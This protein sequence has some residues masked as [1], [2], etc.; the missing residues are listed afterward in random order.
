[1]SD[2]TLIC[3]PEQEEAL[4]GYVLLDGENY[5]DCRDL[6]PGVHFTLGR[7]RAVWRA[8]QVLETA[9][10]SIDIPGVVDV[11]RA[12]DRLTAAGGKGAIVALT[13]PNVASNPTYAGIA[14]ARQALEDSARLRMIAKAADELRASCERR[15]SPS[16]SLAAF[17]SRVYGETTSTRDN[18]PVCLKDSLSDTFAYIQGLQDNPDEGRLKTGFRDLDAKLRL[19]PG[20]FFLLGGRPAMGKSALGDQIACQMAASGH[21]VMEA[22]FEMDVRRQTNLRR[23]ACHSR[24]GISQIREGKMSDGEHARVLTAA[25]TMRPWLGRVYDAGTELITPGALFGA[26]RRLKEEVGL[27]V[28]VV[29]Y[30]Q[31]MRPNGGGGGSNPNAQIAEVSRALKLMARDLDVLVIGMV[32]LSRKVE[33]REN[34]RPMTSDLR[35]SGQLEQDADQI[36]FLYRDE[37]YNPETEE[38]G[39][40]EVI[41]TKQRM[42]STGVVKLDFDGPCTRFSNRHD[43]LREGGWS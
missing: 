22:A 25:G 38:P 29:D 26:C 28:V 2:R 9:G 6:D 24:V 19:E 17:D 36:A 4:C 30:V 13:S 20:D 8:F 35:E 12:S 10:R 16:V 23:L 14:S 42:G 31:L 21:V 41:I 37:Y 43:N 27:G 15:A 33:G 40:C 7:T 34:K 39:V 11:L 5:G 1:M 3:S 32:Q 18:A